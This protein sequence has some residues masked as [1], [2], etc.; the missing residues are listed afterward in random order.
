MRWAAARHLLAA[1]RGSRPSDNGWGA[2]RSSA[3]TSDSLNRRWPPGVRI[4]P[5]RPD[6]AQRVT[7]L[8]STRNR[9]ATSPGVSSRSLLPSTSYPS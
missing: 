5:I 9:V 3:R 6:A 8:G 7:V 4:L 2:P 1:Q